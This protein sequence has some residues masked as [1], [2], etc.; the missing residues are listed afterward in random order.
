MKKRIVV[1]EDDQDIREIVELILVGAD[2]EVTGYDRVVRFWEGL[3]TD[4]P[5]LILLDVMLPDG[6]G[7]D[8]CRE[9]RS[10]QHTANIPVVVMSAAHDHAHVCA[11]AEFVKKPFNIDDL[12]SLVQRRIA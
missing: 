1:V 2:F 11:E 8:I 5:D 9:L 12:I 6:N 4:K 10:I 3:S 7:L